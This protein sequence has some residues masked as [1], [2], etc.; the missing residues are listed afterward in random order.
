MADYAVLMSMDEFN[1]LSRAPESKIN[2]LSAEFDLL[3]AQMQGS[4]ARNSME[5]AFHASPKQLGE[6]AVAAVARK[7][8]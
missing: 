7:R 1:A 6:A 2:A 8:G 4:V 3:L 5:V